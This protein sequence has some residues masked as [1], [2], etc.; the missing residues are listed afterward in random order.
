MPAMMVLMA[1][2]TAGTKRERRYVTELVNVTRSNIGSYT[3]IWIS[4][5]CFISVSCCSQK[6]VLYKHRPK[7]YVYGVCVCVYMYS[8]HKLITSCT[9]VFLMLLQIGQ[10]YWWKGLNKEDEEFE[11]SFNVQACTCLLLDK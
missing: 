8:I 4:S 6:F 1:A 10:T 9:S 2:T 7:F 5:S 3:C 11:V